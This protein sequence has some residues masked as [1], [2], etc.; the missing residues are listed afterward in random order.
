MVIDDVK[1]DEEEF[2][3]HK[4]IKNAGIRVSIKCIK[5]NML[6]GKSMKTK[7]IFLL[8]S[9]DIRK[10]IFYCTRYDFKYYEFDR[11]FIRITSNYDI[12]QIESLYKDGYLIKHK[13][14]HSE[15]EHFHFQGREKTIR[16]VMKR[17][18][19]HDRFIEKY[20]RKG[21]C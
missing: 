6:K 10:F 5:K 18:Y 4:I 8:R 2:I 13:N 14:F 19:E 20:G 17:I 3:I 15:K 12:W 9:R 21:R 16:L 7:T 11:D 1:Q